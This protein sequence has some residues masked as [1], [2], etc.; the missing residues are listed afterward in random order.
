MG[1]GFMRD[2][3]G[4]ISSLFPAGQGWG[5]TASFLA[6]SS[7]LIRSFKPKSEPKPGRYSNVC[8]PSSISP[9]G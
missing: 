6:D 3:L 1:A 2:W 5:E 7:T 9:V 8:P 4:I